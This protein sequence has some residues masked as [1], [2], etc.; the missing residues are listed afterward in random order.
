MNVSLNVVSSVVTL[1]AASKSKEV[2]F[3]NSG[4][5][6]VVALKGLVAGLSALNK[7]CVVRISL[8]SKQT[9]RAIKEWL[10]NWIN[11]G[12]INSKGESVKDADLWS[13]FAELCNNHV[14]QYAWEHA[15]VNA[16]QEVENLPAVRNEEDVVDTVYNTDD[17]DFN[18]VMSYQ[19][20][21]MNEQYDSFSDVMNLMN[22]AEVAQVEAAKE[23]MSVVIF[24]EI[25]QSGLFKTFLCFYLN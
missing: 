7:Q 11:N 24:E 4:S 19:G 3:D 5:S 15:E 16:E 17:Y 2:V 21:D 8:D 10:P 13:Q 20:D 14:V 23:S 9:V 18:Y 6:A 12:F 22:S 25:E 1:S